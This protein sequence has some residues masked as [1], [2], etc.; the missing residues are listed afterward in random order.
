MTIYR[1]QSGYLGRVLGGL[2]GTIWA[3]V[4]TMI[5]TIVI[6]RGDLFSERLQDDIVALA[7]WL[8]GNPT[9]VIG[10]EGGIVG[11]VFGL[12]CLGYGI[13]NVGGALLKSDYTLSLRLDGFP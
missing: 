11:G 7:P 10:I 9:G 8:N 13:Y 2:W 12:F 1:T 6:V 4:G 5:V 3:G